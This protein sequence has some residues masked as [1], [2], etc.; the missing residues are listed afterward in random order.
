MDDGDGGGEEVDDDD[1][2]ET[3][4]PVREGVR[5]KTFFLGLCP[6]LWVGGGQKSQTFSEVSYL[7]A[8][9]V[10]WVILSFIFPPESPRRARWVGGVRC[11]G[12]SR[13]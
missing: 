2:D 13:K 12:Q 3:S 5:K 1:D 6:N 4:F 7:H 10:F 8:Y 9:I 11:L